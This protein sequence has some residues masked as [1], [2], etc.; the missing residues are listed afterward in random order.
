MDGNEML[1]E[2]TDCLNSQNSVKDNAIHLKGRTKE[3]ERIERNRK[4]KNRN[5]L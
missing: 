2:I 4:V 1:Q 3:E 5:G